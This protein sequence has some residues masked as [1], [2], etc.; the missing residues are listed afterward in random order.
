[1]NCCARSWCSS[2]RGSPL[3]VAKTDW[4]SS[5]EI[6]AWFFDE[7]FVLDK[8]YAGSATVGLARSVTAPAVHW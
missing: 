3:S 7:G 1:M 2:L 4:H 6:S 8:K 5:C